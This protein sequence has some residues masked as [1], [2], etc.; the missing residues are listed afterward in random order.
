MAQI[1]WQSRYTY[2]PQHDPMLVLEDID[3]LP[4]GLE[5]RIIRP[6]LLQDIARRIWE[7]EK[8]PDPRVQWGWASA[9]PTKTLT[10]KSTS[11]NFEAG[12][13]AFL[14]HGEGVE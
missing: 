3:V 10:I 5:W 2:T 9:A 4:D 14:T 8:R 13:R 11:G 6:E 1:G 12:T 7:L